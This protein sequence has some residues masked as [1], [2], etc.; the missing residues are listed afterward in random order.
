MVG[1][2]NK[3]P[4]GVSGEWASLRLVLFSMRNADHTFFDMERMIL[5][6]YPRYLNFDFKRFKNIS[7]VSGVLV[8]RIRRNW[9]YTIDFLVA[10]GCQDAECIKLKEWV[11][12]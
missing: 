4:G 7:V 6:E 3:F 9:L 2:S 11:V 5:G 8:R 10:W 1:H 12:L